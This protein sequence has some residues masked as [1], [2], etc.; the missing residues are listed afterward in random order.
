MSKTPQER[1]EK[2]LAEGHWVKEVDE[3]ERGIREAIQAVLDLV[4]VQYEANE[5]MTRLLAESRLEW[6]EVAA[7]NLVR[8]E[9]V[10]AVLRNLLNK[11]D[12]VEASPAYLSVWTIA[13][14]HVG[15]YRGETWT[16]EFEAARAAL[17]DTETEGKL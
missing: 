4:R 9:K 15:P 3:P 7:A 11:M 14:L 2:W 12:R 13:Q 8:A 16:A 10:E 6:P 1:I 17:R 5:E